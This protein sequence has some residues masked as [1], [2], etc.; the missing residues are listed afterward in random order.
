MNA[1]ISEVVA[2]GRQLIEPAPFCVSL[3]LVVALA[4]G[5]IARMITLIE[6]LTVTRS[7][8]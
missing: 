4:T 1:V 5:T 3:A 6:N 7:E 8:S 2:V